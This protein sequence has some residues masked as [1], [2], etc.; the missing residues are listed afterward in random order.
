MFM[1]FLERWITWIDI[2]NKIN[3]ERLELCHNKKLDIIK[4]TNIVYNKLREM[5]ELTKINVRGENNELLRNQ[6][7]W[8]I[9]GTERCANIY[10]LIHGHGEAYKC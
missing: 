4:Q 10:E 5:N 1:N 8:Y 2:S 6:L 7:G 9:K 3:T